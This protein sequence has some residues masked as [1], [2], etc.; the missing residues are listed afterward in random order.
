MR[1]VHGRCDAVG[2]GHDRLRIARPSRQRN[3]KSATAAKSGERDAADR[4]GYLARSVHRSVQAVVEARTTEQ[5]AAGLCEAVVGIEWRALIEEKST[6]RR[7]GTKEDTKRKG[8]WPRIARI[9][10]DRN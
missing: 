5:Q 9:D 3:G 6:R 7:E 4:P 8:F 1:D 10:R 2:G